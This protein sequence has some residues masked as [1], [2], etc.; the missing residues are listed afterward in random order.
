MGLKPTAR[1]AMTPA[2]RASIMWILLLQ[3]CHTCA[4][5]SMML[6]EFEAMLTILVAKNTNIF[7][8]KVPAALIPRAKLLKNCP[9]GDLD[10]DVR[11]AKCP[12]M[13]PYNP[14]NKVHPKI[15]TSFV[16]RC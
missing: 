2:T 15:K 1:K 3:A 13:A 4:G 8:A 6:S 11:S 7:H 5:N 14:S 12:R 16:D 10:Q 9:A